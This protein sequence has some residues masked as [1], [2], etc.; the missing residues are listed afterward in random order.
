MK[1]TTAF[2]LI[3]LFLS[4][5]A[6][7]QER[8]IGVKAKLK[9]KKGQEQQYVFDPNS[10]AM[11]IEF[12]NPESEP[13]YLDKNGY[14]YAPGRG[15]YMKMNLNRMRNIARGFGLVFEDLPSVDYPEGPIIYHGHEIPVQRFPVVEWAFILEPDQFINEDDYD[16]ETVPCIENQS[17]QKFTLKNGRQSGSYVIFDTQGRMIEISRARSG[18]AELEYLEVVVT[19][20][21]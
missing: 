5:P 19:L 14:V 17:C 3:S 16:A 10:M 9:D 20:P 6:L 15:G 18:K 13:I 11:R 21:E 8:T 12:I 2:I 4:F 1:S 7:S